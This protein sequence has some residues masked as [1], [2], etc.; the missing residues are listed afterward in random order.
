MSDLTT[1]YIRAGANPRIYGQAP[2]DVV[3]VHG[4]PGLG[5][6]MAPVARELAS[7]RG[8]LEPI[9]TAASLKG[10]I[11]E[12]RTILA[13]DGDPPVTLIGYSWGAWLSY[14]IAAEY[15]ALAKKLILISRREMR[16]LFCSRNILASE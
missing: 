10:Q 16:G 13:K 9:Q 12:L 6:E 11:E 5:G 4:G 1:E 7:D 14:I 3:V 8:V 15:P 2:F